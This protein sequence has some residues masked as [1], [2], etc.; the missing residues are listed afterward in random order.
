[1]KVFQFEVQSKKRYVSGQVVAKSFA[2]AESKVSKQY[3]GEVIQLS[4]IT[5]QQQ[6][7]IL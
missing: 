4:R 6:K 7:V 2:E 3:K 1:M 5:D